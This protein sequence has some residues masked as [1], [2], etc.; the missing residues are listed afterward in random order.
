MSYV[1]CVDIVRQESREVVHQLLQLGISVNMLTG[2]QES[3]V[4]MVFRLGYIIDIS[5]VYICCD[6]TDRNMFCWTG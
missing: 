1:C 4:K 5:L 3:V 2:D 6:I